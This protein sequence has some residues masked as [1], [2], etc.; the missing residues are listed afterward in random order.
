[1]WGAQARER[2]TANSRV[3]FFSSFPQ[4]ELSGPAGTIIPILCYDELRASAQDI[5]NDTDN[6][7]DETMSEDFSVCMA[8]R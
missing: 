3:H 1:M 8:R 2:Y 7:E 5:F 6:D 4:K